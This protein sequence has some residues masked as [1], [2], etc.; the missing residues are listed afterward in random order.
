MMDEERLKRYFEMEGSIGDLAPQQWEIILNQV[1]AQ[2]Q[3]RFS[4]SLFTWFASLLHVA[5]NS[6]DLS[7]ST[8]PQSLSNE[9]AWSARQRL[10]PASR[11]GWVAVG[12]VLLTTLG[13]AG[14]VGSQTL[15]DKLFSQIIGRWGEDYRSELSHEINLSETI[16]EITVTVDR[17]HF[18]SNRIGI[19]YTV[20]GL[21]RSRSPSEFELQA[22]LMDAGNP[23]V[24]FRGAG[25][26]GVRW[27]SQ[28]RGMEVPADTVKEVAGFDVT[29]ARTDSSGM[30][31]L[32]VVSVDEYEWDGSLWLR[33][34]MIGPFKFN[35]AVPFVPSTDK[36]VV[37]V[38]SIVEA[39]GVPVRLEEVTITPAEM[40]AL[41][42]V[43]RT[44]E[45]RWA[46]VHPGHVTLSVPGE[47]VSGT[48]QPT[49]Y[50]VTT[51]G[52][53]PDYF[54][55]R[56]RVNWDVEPGEWTLTVENLQG[57][58]DAYDL[59]GPWVFQ[60]DVPNGANG[61]GR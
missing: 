58:F 26:S 42:R 30:Q 25:G 51:L 27:D 45:Q 32:F 36:R 60:F 53:T 1:K 38:G 29:G 17:A 22:E 10:I 15:G 8:N 5:D 19:E 4:W 11:L 21:P 48:P 18:D 2:R 37:R 3:R 20:T 40:T 43:D 55:A 34:R 28:I 41:I 9:R 39:S 23:S 56:F 61:V 13:A 16:E 54:L 50:V 47:W 44:A 35:F 24:R 59:D 33:D 31:L 7:P 46:G 52:D 6:G 14:Y 49:A 12:I 57:A